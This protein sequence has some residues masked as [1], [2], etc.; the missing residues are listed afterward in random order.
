MDPTAVQLRSEKMVNT[1]RLKF[2]PGMNLKSNQPICWTITADLSLWFL[3]YYIYKLRRP[4]HPI[5]VY[6]T[7]TGVT[8]IEG[9][10]AL[11]RVQS[12]TLH[13]QQ[14]TR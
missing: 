4:F 11:H 2:Q 9:I 13:F 6:R 8:S 10:P 5:S 12:S 14:R 1:T 3:F 7:I